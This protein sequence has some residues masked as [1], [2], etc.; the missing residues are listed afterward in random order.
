M[1]MLL[2]SLAS[3]SGSGIHR[4]PQLWC[5]SQMQLGSPIAEAVAYAGSYSSNSTP[6]LGTSI[7]C[8]CGPK[9]KQKKKKKKKK[10]N[11]G[12]AEDSLSRQVASNKLTPPPLLLSLESPLTLL[13]FSRS[14]AGSWPGP[15]SSRVHMLCSTFFCL[16]RV[17]S[18]PSFNCLTLSTA[19][20]QS[21]WVSL[22]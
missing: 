8:Q 7:Y 2:H 17:S 21:G 11:R 20:P 4:S 12:H 22:V 9:S 18:P 6:S 10:K 15:A 5:R 16:F 1:R 13:C 19:S 3:L 14:S